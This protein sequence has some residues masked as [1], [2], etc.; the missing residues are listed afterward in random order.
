MN[1]NKPIIMK[2]FVYGECAFTSD[3]ES[4]SER[5][6]PGT[7]MRELAEKFRSHAFLLK[8]ITLINTANNL[9][10]SCVQL[11]RLFCFRSQYK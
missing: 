9:N 8:R 1:I 10:F 5:V 7:E 11:K 4:C 2:E 6:G 3:S